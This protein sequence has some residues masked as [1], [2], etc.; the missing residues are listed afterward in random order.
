MRWYYAASNRNGIIMIIVIASAKGGSGKSTT[1]M[2]LAEYLSRRR[3]LKRV[4]LLDAD[5]DNRSASKWYGRGDGWGFKL[6]SPGE[7]V[8]GEF[9]ALVIDAGA[10]PD[11]DELGALLEGADL[12][13]IPTAPTGLDV[14]S[15]VE[16]ASRFEDDGSIKLLVGLAQPGRSKQGADAV[17]ALEEFG[18]PVCPQVIHR[19]TAIASVATNGET[20]ATAKGKPAAQAWKE[21][22]A[23]FKWLLQGVL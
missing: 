8:E 11:D 9:D 19:R 18:L 4:V 15:A 10:A 23:A 6:V 13:I 7:D 21:Y 5:P 16:V 1:A 22:Q 12:L 17:A 2:H 14:E 3:S 20:V